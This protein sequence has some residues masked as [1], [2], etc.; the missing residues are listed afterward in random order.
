[1]Q[2]FLF[3]VMWF[4]GIYINGFVPGPEGSGVSFLL[5][6]AVA[7]HFAVGITL[8][9]L[10]AAIFSLALRFKLKRTALLSGLAFSGIVIAATGGLSF[11]F[12]VGN[13]N[14]DSMLMA[15]SFITALYVSFL[16]ILNPAKFRAQG[17]PV[18]LSLAVLLLFY[19][20]FLSGMY[21]NI[22]VAFKVFSEPPAI[23]SRMLGGMVVSPPVLLHEIS[24]TLLFALIIVLTMSLYL[25]R[26][27][28]AIRGAIASALVGYSFLEGLTMN[29]LPLFQQPGTSIISQ[30]FILSTI[31][32]LA[33]AVGFLCAIIACM[34]VLESI[35]RSNE[36]RQIAAV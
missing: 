4:L 33:S 31:A 2:I 28:L 10:A 8:A 16:A 27:K 29:I 15:T 26:S 24:G 12:G 13:Q 11:V 21:T 34:S 9:V 17:N 1:M 20:T 5:I 35:T 18:R 6:P 30:G 22:F 25:T 3:V 19:V 32:P 7:A 23:A 36:T 14:I